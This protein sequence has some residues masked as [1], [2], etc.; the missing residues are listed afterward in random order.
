MPIFTHDMSA[1]ELLFPLVAK[2]IVIG[3]NSQ[4]RGTHKQKWQGCAYRCIKSRGHQ[5]QFSCIKRG[6]LGD[7]SEKGVIWCEIFAAICKNIFQNFMILPEN[8]DQKN[9]NMGLL[10]MKLGMRGIQWQTNAEKGFFWQ[11]Y[12]VYRP[13]GVPP[14][15]SP[16]HPPNPRCK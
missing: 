7:R 1:S 15:H 4:G 3:C 8:F 9:K 10:G 2:Q 11:A 5:W 12:N 16:T 6:S 14:P 13:V